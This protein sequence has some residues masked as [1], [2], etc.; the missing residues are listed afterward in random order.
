MVSHLDPVYC[1]ASLINESGNFT[2]ATQNTGNTGSFSVHRKR[3][4]REVGSL[5]F[6]LKLTLSYTPCGKA[7]C[8]ANVLAHQLGWAVL[9]QDRKSGLLLHKHWGLPALEAP[10]S[11]CLLL[12]APRHSTRTHA[13]LHA[14]LYTNYLSCTGP[15]GWPAGQVLE[16]QHYQGRQQQCEP[17]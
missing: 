9:L 5:F 14:E 15:P 13:C 12:P 17:L 10:A 11:L 4:Q 1:L 6:T 3:K 7:A 8:F 16:P 2:S